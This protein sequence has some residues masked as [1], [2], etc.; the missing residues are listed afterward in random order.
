M[1]GHLDPTTAVQRRHERSLAAWTFA[2]AIV[3]LGVK[4]AAWWFTRSTALWSDAVE[5]IVNV[6]AGGMALASLAWAARPADET[7]PYGHGRIEFVTAAFEGGM[8]LLAAAAIAIRGV[9]GLFAPTLDAGM[10]G[11]GLWL[12]GGTAV[13]NAL[14]GAWLMR[15]GARHGSIVLRAGGIHLLTDA[16]STLI[17][18][19]ALLLVEWTGQ[20]MWDPIGAIALGAGALLAGIR[21]VRE[22]LGLLLDESDA[23][24]ARVI[25]DVLTRRTQASA[26]AERLCSF[27]K[28]RH[29]HVGREHWIDFHVQLPATLDIATAH[30]IAKRAEDELESLLPGTATAH[31]EPCVDQ[32]CDRCGP[33][34]AQRP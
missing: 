1:M 18:I 17:G 11:R 7:H 3:I 27:H 19:A 6:I 13:A 14:M 33:T 31:V 16:G 28:I 10:I 2:L 29:R 34:R 32:A 30:S 20:P 24:D 8:V 15:H 5:S 26:G 25:H 21:L 9:E 22:A 12:A 4:A 23:A